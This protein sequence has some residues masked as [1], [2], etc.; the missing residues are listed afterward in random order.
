MG[1]SDAIFVIYVYLQIKKYQY[2]NLFII[3]TPKPLRAVG[4]LFSPIVSGWEGRR[5]EEVCSACILETV[6]CRKLILGRDID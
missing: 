3:V 1:I 6:R 4:V 5:R 2:T